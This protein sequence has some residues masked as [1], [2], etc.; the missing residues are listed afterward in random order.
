MNKFKHI[1]NFDFLRSIPTENING[2]RYYAID[3]DIKYPSITTIMSTLPDKVKG[4]SDWRKRVGEKEA[5][6]ISTQA[7][8]KG[9]VV[10]DII[11]KYLGIPRDD[12]GGI[13]GIIGVI[14]LLYL[15]RRESKNKK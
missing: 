11:E 3:D 15:W 5:N 1:G 8:R 4:L 2:K 12:I 13:M 10:H 14:V 6:K 9:T 7:S